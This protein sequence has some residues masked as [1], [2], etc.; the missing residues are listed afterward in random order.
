[1]V[2]IEQIITES[3]GVDVFPTGD[4]TSGYLQFE[5]KEPYQARSVSFTHAAV[6][7]GEKPAVTKAGTP[8]PSG[9]A[10]KLEV[11][12]DGIQFR[13]AANLGIISSALNRVDF[14]VAKGRYFRLSSSQ[15]HH[16]SMVRFSGAE[17]IS[18]WKT[19]AN[20]ISG[21]DN[22]APTANIQAA[23]IINPGSIVNLSHLMDKDGNLRWDAPAGDWVILRLGYA[24]KGTV[25]NAAP[26][27]GEGLEID[28]YSKEAMD[29]HFTA[30]MSELL[31]TMA[32]LA[33]KGKVFL[34][35]DSWEVG[36]QNW[37]P[38]FQEEFLQHA[39]YDLTNYLPA[40][41]GRVVGA[42]KSLT[43]SSGTCEGP[44]PILSPIIITVIL[45]NFAKHTVFLQ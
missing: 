11:S 25:N 23:S 6:V 14:P 42:P 5:F 4:G 15:P 20:Y 22:A 17:R 31:P 10:L 37:T 36:I 16:Y 3:Q 2:Q 9:G 43:G 34:E 21:G 45:I 32:P 35:I 38:G 28:K 1:M 29:M 41:T 12:D 27:G 39:G 26:E 44:R 24:A 18:E 13:E 30:M 8:D 7:A 40:M 19:K 33:E